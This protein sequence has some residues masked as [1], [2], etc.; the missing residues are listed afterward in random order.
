[1]AG[2]NMQLENP[3]ILNHSLGPFGDFLSIRPLRVDAGVAVVELRVEEKYFN[4]FG[5]VHCGVIYSLV[6]YA[7]GYASQSILKEGDMSATIQADIQFLAPAKDGILQCTSR[8]KK[9]GKQILYL[10]STVLC[11]DKTIAESMGTYFV[12]SRKR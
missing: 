7:M 6:E 8:I 1:M 5:A 3:D 4:P 2:K 12:R 11:D 10:A 9:K